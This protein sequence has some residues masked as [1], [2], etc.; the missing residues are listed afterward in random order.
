MSEEM[1]SDDELEAANE[2]GMSLEEFIEH[3]R[4]K[5][6]RGLHEEY[7]EIK[8]RAASGSFNHARSTIAEQ[9]TLNCYK[10]L[11]GLRDY[12][13]LTSTAP[14]PTAFTAPQQI[15]VQQQHQ[16]PQQPQFIAPQH[17]WKT[18]GAEN[19]PPGM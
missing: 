4:V 11:Q 16:Q 14:H 15:P 9:A 12:N 13:A 2:V 18:P 8:A 5:G 10:D 7:A 3:V 17:C 1:S 19:A 6:R